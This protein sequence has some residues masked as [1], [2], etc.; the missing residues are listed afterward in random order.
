LKLNYVE[1]SNVK[2][3]SQ[4]WIID[5]KTTKTSWCSTKVA[6]LGHGRVKLY[7]IPE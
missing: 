4:Q 5:T 1:N 3:A 6:S 7:L 2:Q